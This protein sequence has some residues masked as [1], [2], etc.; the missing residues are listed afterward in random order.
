MASGLSDDELA[1]VPSRFNACTQQSDGTLLLYNTFMGS[2]ARVPESGAG[3]VRQALAAGLLGMP[4][5]ILAELCFNGFF[6]F[7]KGEGVEYVVMIAVAAAAIAAIG[8]GE[9]SLDH[10]FGWDDRNGWT[11]V[12]IAVG[13]GLGA[14]IVQLALFWRNPR[15]AAVTA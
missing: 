14:A 4:T 11:S 9:I 15:K 10:A 2:F 3:E 6:V 12:A 8:P 7:R 13:I 5:G 1:W